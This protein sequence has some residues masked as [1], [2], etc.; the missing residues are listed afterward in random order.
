[1]EARIVI[2]SIEPTTLTGEYP[3]KAVIGETVPVSADIYKEGHDVIAARV[4]W[5]PAGGKAFKSAPLTLGMN[6]RWTG[7]LV[8]DHVGMHE[9]VVESWLDVYATWRHKTEVKLQAL[10]DVSVELA[11]GNLFFLQ[12]A[13][14]A[15]LKALKD[16]LSGVATMLLDDSLDQTARVHSA[17]TNELVALV[18]GPGKTDHITRS[19]PKKLWVST[20]R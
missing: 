12:R 14:E 11:E 8:V 1:M 18:S 16:K 2:D 13:K 4:S 20:L 15:G 19:K 3:T 17:M 9:F 7:E 10:Q 6:D 5:R